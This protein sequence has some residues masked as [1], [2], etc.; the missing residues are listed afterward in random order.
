MAEKKIKVFI[1]QEACVGCGA[2]TSLCGDVFELDEEGKSQITKKFRGD[3]PAEGEV[4]ED[5]ESC[6]KDAASAC[7][8]QAIQVEE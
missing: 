4:G 1:D 8:A 2:C 5:L 3:S 6:V 7:P